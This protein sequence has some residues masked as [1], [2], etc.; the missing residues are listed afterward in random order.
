MHRTIGRAVLLAWLVVVTACNGGDADDAR[1]PTTTSA[2]TTTTTTTAPAPTTTTTP[3]AGPAPW[4][5]I[6]RD[7]FERSWAL[8]ANPDPNA[9]GALYSTNCPCHTIFLEDIQGLLDRGEHLEGVPPA[10][11]AVRLEGQGD[12]GPFQRLTVKLVYGPQRVVDSTGAVLGETP[13]REPLCVSVLVAATGPNQSYQVHDYL[14]PQR[15]P[16]GL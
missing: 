1:G 13:G 2:E 15:C 16:D 14:I 4:T 6:V 10:P 9:V 7:L 5:E 12:S 8:Q 3:I 11:V